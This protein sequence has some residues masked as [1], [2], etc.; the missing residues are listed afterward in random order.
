MEIEPE[1][2]NNNVFTIH[3]AMTYTK[4]DF[5]FCISPSKK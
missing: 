3:I 4:N 2:T 1:T 5:V